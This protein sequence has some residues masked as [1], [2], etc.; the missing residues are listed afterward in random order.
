MKSGHYGFV[1]GNVILPQL[2]PFSRGLIYFACNAINR[3][4]FFNTEMQAGKNF[5]LIL[6]A[7]RTS[8]HLFHIFGK[9]SEQFA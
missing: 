4:V 6:D 7:L 9:S 8:E 3:I 1:L 2:T 5:D